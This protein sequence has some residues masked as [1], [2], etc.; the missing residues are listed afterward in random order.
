M[1]RFLLLAFCACLGTTGLYAQVVK[2]V[3]R[4][5]LPMNNRAGDDSD[6]YDKGS[7]DVFSF[8]WFS[9]DYPST[10]GDGQPTT[11]SAI[12]CMPDGNGEGTVINNVIAGC[13]ITITSNK[14][15][16]TEYNTS[17]ST[18]SDLYFTMLMAGGSILYQQDDNA[19]NN[20]VIL[21][22]YEGYGIT[23]ER[24]HPYLCGE[25]TGRQVADAVRYGIELYQSDAMLQDIRRPLKENWHTICTGYSQGGAVAMATQRYIEEQGLSGQLHLAG[26]FCGDGPY[27]PTA[28]VLY[29][30]EQDREGNELVMPVVL[31]LI[32]KGMCEYDEALEGCQVS[33]FLVDRFLETGVL[34]WI[35]EKEWNTDDIT[36]EFKRLYN[37]G[38][39]GDV[40]YFHPVLTSKW[41]AMLK[42]ILKPEVYDYL[43]GLLD[44]YPDYVAGDIPMP[45]G[46]TPSEKLLRAMMH[47]D[48]TLGWT[49]EHPVCLYH[50]T[51]DDVVPYQ[52]CLMAEQRFGD[53]VKF[54]P[55]PMNGGHVDTGMEFFLNPQR[56]EGIRQL[57][58]M[59][60]DGVVSVQAAK[61]HPDRWYD[62]FGRPVV[63]P[64]SKGVYIREG[65]KILV[66]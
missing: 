17:G 58:A 60:D 59:A 61:A 7:D 49:P 29:Y 24:A 50:S 34:E 47:N 20:L 23:K 66:K 1:K 54:F 3:G 40:T 25:T 51:G 30:L 37:E 65:K 13:H 38:K 15:C 55:S 2:R 42:N 48:L 43:N 10:S 57:A 4:T 31:P 18:F 21:P 35:A 41:Q 26:S 44:A 27:S 32:L 22:D 16:P 8:C 5:T 64:L 28:T 52:N 53:M 6:F 33:D 63:K 9:Y 56:L 45:E 11:L 14:E 39:D 19:Y 46:D 12:A 36:D 62:V